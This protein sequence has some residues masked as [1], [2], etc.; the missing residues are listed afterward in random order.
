[1]ALRNRWAMTTNRWRKLSPAINRYVAKGIVLDDDPRI[2]R[3]PLRRQRGHQEPGRLAP[4]MES[5]ITSVRVGVTNLADG[6]RPDCSSSRCPSRLKVPHAADQRSAAVLPAAL[7]HAG[8]RSRHRDNLISTSGRRRCP[9]RCCSSPVRPASRCW[10]RVHRLA[11]AAC[12][13]CMDA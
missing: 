7:R 1:M 10:Q 2:T 12:V 5:N 11:V 9:V 8:L 13:H 6:R 4:G 3:V